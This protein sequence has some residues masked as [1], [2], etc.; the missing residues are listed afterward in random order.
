MK[1]R[2][3]IALLIVVLFLL[4]TGTIAAYQSRSK[5]IAV[6]DDGKVTQ[7]ETFDVYVKEFLE[8]A[9][10]KLNEN[11]VVQPDLMTEIENGMKINIDRFKPTISLTINGTTTTFE[12]TDKTVEEVLKSKGI[13]LTEGSEVVPSI[14]TPLVDKMEIDV[15]T[16]EI[17][18][19]IRTV[20]IPF[21]REVKMSSELEPGVQKVKTPGKKGIK[22]QTVE[23]VH[24]GGVPVEETIKQV[25]IKEEP[26]KEVVVEGKKNVI[27]DQHTGKKY[28]YSSALTLEATAYT[29][30]PGDQWYNKTATGRPTFKGMVAVDPKV[31]PLDTVLY[32]EGYGIAIAGDTGGAIKGHDIDLFFDSSSEVYNFGRKNKKVYILKDQNIDVR[33]ERTQY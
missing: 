21:E 7:Y 26:V 4:G 14:D 8:T 17:K 13:E 31:I 22:E 12:S 18:T 24:F 1:N 2:R 30:V 3:R 32:V 16:K 20:E 9:E 27:V 29:D 6:I 10:I 23:I 15:K 25:I 28:E 33:A 19:E 11:D 5:T